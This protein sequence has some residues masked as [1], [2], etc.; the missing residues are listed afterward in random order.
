L[1]PAGDQPLAARGEP[2]H[3]THYSVIDADG[4]AVAVTTT[5][6]SLYGNAL[7]VTG[8]GFLMN[9]EMDVFTTRPGMPNQ[10]GLVQGE[11]NAI[12][13]GKRMLSAMSPTIVLDAAGYVRL[14]TG[15]PGGPTIITTVAQIVSNIVD[16]GMGVADASA[17]P[18]VHH[19]H[20]PDVLRFE[21]AGL[22]PEIVAELEA[23]GHQVGG[24]SGYSGDVQSILVLPDG[25]LSA[26]ADPRRGGTALGVREDT[27]VLQ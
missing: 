15:T 19:Q 3:T 24:R 14:I 8:A 21:V 4:G 9:N 17:A 18:R 11:S 1:D 22:R 26:S 2:G 23:R 13:G 27:Q 5:L 7:M 12:A 10:F 16:F 6:N 20:L 25:T